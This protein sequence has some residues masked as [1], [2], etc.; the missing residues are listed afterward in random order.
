M[1]ITLNITEDSKVELVKDSCEA[2]QGEKNVTI[3]K[4]NFPSTI[5]GY[6]IDNYTKHIEFCECKELGECV[7]FFDVVEGDTYKLCDICTQFEKIMIQF[8]LKNFVDEA[9][10]IV[11]KTIP[12]ALEFCESINAEN[13]KQGQVVLLCLEEIENAWEEF[14]KAHTLRIIYR[15]GDVPKADATSLGDTIFYLGA[16]STNP[17]VLTY[18]HYYRCNFANDKYEWTDLTIDPNLADV[19]N[20][21]REISKNQ[22]M[23]LWVDTK[24]KLK[25]E[26]IQPNTIYIPE[27]HDMKETFDEILTE[28]TEDENYNILYPKKD[29]NGAYV[30]NDIILP[31]QR[32]VYDGQENLNNGDLLIELRHPVEDYQHLKFKL[33]AYDTVIWAETSVPTFGDITKILVYLPLDDGIHV[34]NVL[35]YFEDRTHIRLYGVQGVEWDTLN[36]FGL[37][38]MKIYQIFE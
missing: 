27:D 7:K 17:Y 38:L 22:T 6:S 26:M 18:G 33:F 36:T 3:L 19:A 2:V 30:Q 37:Y 24:E 16:N 31:V 1:E 11:W 32:I 35:F 13:S 34:F 29:K 4:L 9:E 23:Q 5:R 28:M 15:V 20:G 10:P 25:N 14:I 21:I 12:F 8:T